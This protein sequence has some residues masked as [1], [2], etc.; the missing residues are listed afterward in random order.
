MS[1]FSK[2]FTPDERDL[3]DRQ[4]RL[5][6]WDQKILKESKVLIAGVGGLGCETA[7]NLA[8][9]GVGT[10]YLVDLDIIEHSNLNRQILFSDA[11]MGE[12]K[13]NVAARKLKE[14][15][16]HVKTYPFYTSL[17]RLDPRVY[18]ASDIIIGGLDSMNA[19]YNLNA[20]CVRFR[21]PLLDGG[22]SGYHGHI[23]TIFPH[24]NACFECYPLPAIESD[25]M[26]ACTVVGKPRKR[27][28]C[29]FKGYLYFEEKYDNPPDPKNEQHVIFI[30]EYANRLAEENNFL[31]LF[32][33]DEVVHLINR[34]DPGVITI[35]SII[36]SIQSHESVKIL[37]WLKGNKSLGEPIKEYLVFNAMTMK[38]YPI[39]KKIN[40]ECPQCGENVRRVNIKI[41]KSS[42]AQKIIDILTN[43]G[44]DLNPEMEPMLTIMDFNMIK[45]IDL[46]KTIAENELRHLELLTAV[47]FNGGSIFITLKLK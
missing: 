47:G 46:D 43:N 27:V 18:A 10:L 8:M 34:H 14:I 2:E 19:R 31:P 22:V 21:K 28:H 17:E 33:K 7:K 5:N 30:M 6:G 20:Q 36:A 24:E 44:Y 1:F 26:A 45:E 29:V 37:H 40:L 25:E 16:T 38:I 3:Y 23:Y 4:F 39:E 32:K 41:K 11:K 12:P 15:N 9:L 13:A 35:N 42:Q